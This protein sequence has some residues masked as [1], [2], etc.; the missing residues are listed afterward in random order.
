MLA[1]I[2]LGLVHLHRFGFL[3]LDLKVENIMLDHAGHVKLV[4]FGLAVELLK[5][6]DTTGQQAEG[7]AGDNGDGDEEHGSTIEEM[8]IDTAGSRTN[9]APE[10]L[11][12]KN[13]KKIGGRFSDWWGLGLVAH[14][15]L[16]GKPPWSSLTDS[17]V[18][19]SEI[20]HLKV[21]AP[22]GVSRQAGKFIVTLLQK[23]RRLRLG[24]QSDNEVLACSFFE[25]VDWGAMERGETKPAFV[26][27][28]GCVLQEDAAGALKM[29]KEVVSCGAASSS[30]GS[31]ASSNPVE[32][33]LLRTENAPR[34]CLESTESSG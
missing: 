28:A 26:P 15:L 12:P 20:K 32:L 13:G 25:G 18:I 2:S 5:R 21:E 19:R 7:E 22:R 29:Y 1:E 33:G 10:L 24:Y 3:H 14:D 31:S 6:T 30:S 11:L 16:V 9:M 23:D 27:L 4:D 17:Q 8:V 34:L